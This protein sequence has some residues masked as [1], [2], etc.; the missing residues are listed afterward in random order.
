[1][2]TLALTVTALAA[3]SAAQ[4]SH[5]ECTQQD[6]TTKMQ[7]ILASDEYREVVS[8]AGEMEQPSTERSL[9]KSG[10]RM[11]G[12]RGG[13]VG[14]EVMQEEDNAKARNSAMATVADT[15]AVTTTLNDA[16][17]ALGRGD[18]AT[19]CML[20]DKLIVDLAIQ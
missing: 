19:A 4:L 12:G 9:M 15:K 20:Y 10:L 16:G 14:A 17:T 2:K 5:A 13:A 18:Y 1:M 6:A 7:K 8:K 3:L 11:F